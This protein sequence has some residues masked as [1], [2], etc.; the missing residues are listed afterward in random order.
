M[1]Y[2]WIEAKYI[3]QVSFRLRNFKHHRNTF[4]FSCPFCGD[5]KTDRRKARGYLYLRNGR[6]KYFCHNCNISGINTEKLLLHIDP[7][8]HGEYLKE[9]LQ[10]YYADRPKPEVQVFAEKMKTPRFRK[11]SPLV[12]LKKISQ[13]SPDH[14]AKLYVEDRLIPSSVHHKL[15][16]C[17]K[18]KKWSNE[19]A[20]DTFESLQY[21][22]PRLIIPLI[23]VDQRLFGFQGRSFDPN[24]KLKYITVMIDKSMPKLYGL[25]SL[26]RRQ[27]ILCVEGPID[28]MFLPNCL[29]SAGSDITSN[30]DFVSEDHKQFT[31]VYDNEPRSRQ[32]I[33]KIEKAINRGF[34]VCIWPSSIHQKDVNAMVLAGIKPAE[35]VEIIKQNTYHGL[36]AHAMLSSW[37]KV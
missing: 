7:S 14:P 4:N 22:E 31:I 13:L 30:L 11:E 27:D 33:E 24:S 35:I 19:C 8:T 9:R 20:P 17:P 32:T 25:D 1:S 3:Q 5:S 36:R 26:D 6:Y 12:H 23:D 37:K 29:A 18:F 28:S 2:A 16:L 21:D 10:A 34:N 15:F